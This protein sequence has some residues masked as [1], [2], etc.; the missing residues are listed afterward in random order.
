[1]KQDKHDIPY[2]HKFGGYIDTPSKQ[3]LQMNKKLI[4]S[5]PIIDIISPGIFAG[6]FTGTDF[7]DKLGIIAE[8]FE[9]VFGEEET[10]ESAGLAVAGFDVHVMDAECCLILIGKMGQRVPN[11]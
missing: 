5:K 2:K 4:I 9:D 11:K 3:E 10:G 1:M 6:L 8:S 7:L